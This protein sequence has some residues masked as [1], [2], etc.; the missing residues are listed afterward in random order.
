MCGARASHGPFDRRRAMTSHPS[1]RSTIITSCTLR[2]ASRSPRSGRRTGRT[3]SGSIRME[4]GI[5]CGSRRYRPGR[6]SVGRLRVVSGPAPRTTPRSRPRCTVGPTGQVKALDQACTAPSFGP[7]R[8]RTSRNA[9]PG[10][11]YRTRRRNDFTFDSGFDRSGRSTASVASSARTGTSDGSSD[12]P[13]LRRRLAPGRHVLVERR[14]ALV[15]AGSS[16]PP[17]CIERIAFASSSYDSASHL[18][19]A[20][21]TSGAGMD[22]EMNS[23]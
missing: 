23:P 15:R 9:L 8:P 1:L 6:W 18:I 7:L 4:G 22:G 5:D 13:G 17:Y 12:R 21:F 16:L 2:R 19:A 11:R 10:S 20:S 3:G 14:Y